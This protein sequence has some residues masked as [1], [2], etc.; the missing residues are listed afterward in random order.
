MISLWSD[1][2][3][4]I[5]HLTITALFVGTLPGIG[6]ADTR[7]ICE[8]AGREYLALYEAGEAELTL[9]PD[10]NATHYTIIIDDNSDKSHIVTAETPNNGPTVRLHL[11]PYTK[12]E[13]WSNGQLFQTDACYVN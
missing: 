6:H 3:G 5:W 2:M 9:N 10:S 11:R 13:F 7:L 4:K 12:I 1:S 8:N